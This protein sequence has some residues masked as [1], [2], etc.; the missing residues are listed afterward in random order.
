M[1]KPT[2]Q[3]PQWVVEEIREAYALGGVSQAQLAK[4]LGVSETT[5][6]RII[7]RLG[8][9]QREAITRAR[10]PISPEMAEEAEKSLQRLLKMRAG[11][12]PDTGE[13]EKKEESAIDI[14]M[15]KR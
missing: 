5:V 3:V 15:K 10:D 6:F 4:R 7:Q 14:F 11:I 12:N 13:A 2:A 8:A 1:G 9:Y